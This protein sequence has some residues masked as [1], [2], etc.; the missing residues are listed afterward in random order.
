MNALGQ[1]HNV[2]VVD[3]TAAYTAAMADGVAATDLLDKMHPTALGH[4]VLAAAIRTTLNDNGWPYNPSS[5]TGGTLPDLGIDDVPNP[6]WTDDAGAGSPQVKLFELTPEEQ[7]AMDDARKAMEARG[8][9][10]PDAVQ[11]R[12]AGAPGSGAA[13]APAD[14]RPM[15]WIRRVSA[16]HGRPPSPAGG[17]PP[18]AVKLLD[19]EASARVKS[20][21]S[22]R[23]KVRRDIAEV[24]VVATDAAGREAE[25]GSSPDAPRFHWSWGDKWREMASAK[26]MPTS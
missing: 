9:P 19:A 4:S 20:A 12:N 21:A 8:P 5:P 7:Q 10:E 16:V 11:P 25:Q 1:F 6:Q 13:L 3:V 18:Y 17:T 15:G 24:T 23:L 2:P 26:A 14:G 22:F